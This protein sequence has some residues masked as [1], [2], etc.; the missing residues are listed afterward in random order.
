MAA[1]S[2]TAAGAA[3]D[4]SG[5][6]DRHGPGW[7]EQARSNVYWAVAHGLPRLVMRAAARRGD[8]QG[9]LLLAP[10]SGDQVWDLLAEARARGPV[11][12]SRLSYLTVDHAAVK[13]VLS[14]PDFR[15]G[16]PVR[17][18]ST[19][20][21]LLDRTAPRVP[22][23]LEPPSLLVTEP[24]DHTRYRKLVNRV[25]T[26]RAVEQLR[27]TRER[28]PPPEVAHGRERRSAATVDAFLPQLL[29]GGA[30]PF[31]HA[32]DRG[33][34][35]RSP[36][37]RQLVREAGGLLHLVVGDLLEPLLRQQL[38]VTTACTRVPRRRW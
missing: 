14:S 2:L 37:T 22:H 18:D 4:A 36:V 19:I 20:G 26:V 10:T 11:L 25:F 6:R 29:A 24:P 17:A 5:G 30:G 13:E 28:R 12:R 16:T 8:L 7:Q 15:S 35:H 31:V 34:A 9:R 27:L 32:D 3:L 23:P 38:S 21:R 1:D 33:V